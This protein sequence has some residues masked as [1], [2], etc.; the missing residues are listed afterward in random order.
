[1][2]IIF[3]LSKGCKSVLTL[4]IKSINLYLIIAKQSFIADSFPSDKSLKASPTSSLQTIYVVNK[5][6]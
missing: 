6:I 2:L 1:M 3:P 5:A 4:L